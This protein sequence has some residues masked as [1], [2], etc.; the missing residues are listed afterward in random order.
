M[1]KFCASHPANS[2]LEFLIN[3]QLNVDVLYD[4]KNLVAWKFY[5]FVFFTRTRQRTVLVF[6]FFLIIGRA[7]K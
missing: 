6:E 5:L 7:Q 4:K 1:A 3:D 2:T